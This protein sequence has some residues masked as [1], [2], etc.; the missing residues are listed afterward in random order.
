MSISA[1][2]LIVEDEEDLTI[3]LRYNLEAEG[4]EIFSA[5]CHEEATNIL[6]EN[7]PDIILLDWML[8]EVSGIKL[9]KR[10]RA[11]PRVKNIP[12]IMLTARGEEDEKIRGLTTG[13]DDYMVK[14]FSMLEL[15]A[16]INALLRRTNPEIIS[17]KLIVGEL[18]LDKVSHRIIR[19]GKEI[20]LG[21]K[22][23]D[24]LEY[25]M[26]KPGRV[27][28]REQLLN[29]I[30]GNDVFVDERTVDVHVGRLRKTLNK[31]F[32]KDPI[33]TVRGVGYAFDEKFIN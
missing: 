19:D 23:Y 15:I 8:P 25:L 11:N 21:P 13:A 22:E 27:R 4:F 28:T 10:W 33:R 9:C 32:T 3:L 2:I 12:I 20:H 17:D 31:G 29:N 6:A 24:L 16:R 14:P 26:A 1:K 7:L 30:W 18:E 5:N